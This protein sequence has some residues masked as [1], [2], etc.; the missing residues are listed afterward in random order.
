MGGLPYILNII[1]LIES[2]VD[3]VF[4]EDD[5]SSSDLE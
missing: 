1:A 5:I 2:V 4:G 3:Y